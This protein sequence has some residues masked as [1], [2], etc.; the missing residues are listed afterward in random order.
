MNK[1]EAWRLANDI[2]DLVA[3]VFTSDTETGG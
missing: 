3:T 1:D 2:D